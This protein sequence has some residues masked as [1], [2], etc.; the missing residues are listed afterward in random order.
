MAPNA[1]RTRPLLAVT[2]RRCRTCRSRIRVFRAIGVPRAD[3]PAAHAR[4]P[5]VRAAGELR[6]TYAVPDDVDAVAAANRATTFST[7][8]ELYICAQ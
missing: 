1:P 5:A 3:T 8:A 2:P 6:S 4:L 7:P